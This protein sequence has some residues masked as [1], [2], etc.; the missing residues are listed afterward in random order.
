MSSDLKPTIIN[1]EKQLQ[2]LIFAQTLIKDAT[3]IEITNLQTQFDQTLEILQ[4]L[5]YE[6]TLEYP[7]VKPRRKSRNFLKTFCRQQKQYY[8][9]QKS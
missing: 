4:A 8:N 6:F 3:P 1:I 9:K 2:N 7:L 5:E